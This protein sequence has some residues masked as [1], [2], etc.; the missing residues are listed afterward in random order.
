M[1]CRSNEMEIN[2]IESTAERGNQ[3]ALAMVVS[4]KKSKKSK[5]EKKETQVYKNA[6]RFLASLCKNRICMTP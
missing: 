6:S 2:R 5:N 4:N 1:K 3:Y